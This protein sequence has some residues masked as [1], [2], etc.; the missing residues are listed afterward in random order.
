MTLISL[1]A[2]G[3]T[4]RVPLF[5]D[6]DLTLG[7]G[8]RLGLV[9]ANGRGKS[10][11]LRLIAGEGE[12][13]TG[14]I[15]R[16]R[17][18]RVGL[19]T[20]D[21]PTDLL[22]LTFRAAVMGDLDPDESWR[23]DIALD[24]F[25][26]PDA[27]RERPLAALSG[28]WQRTAMLARVWLG[29]PDVLLLDEP[30]NHLDLSRI[31][32][33]ERW[34]AALPRDMAVI[35]ASHDRAFLDAVCTRTLFLRP[36]ASEVFALPYTRARTALDE[37]D[38][39]RER[40]FQNDIARADQLRRQAAK[41]KNIGINSGSDLLVVKTKQ[42]TERA[43]K[44]EAAARPAHKEQ[45]SGAIRLAGAGS[46]AR[47]LLTLDDAEISA[48]DG[49]VLFRTGKLWISPG[50]RVVVLGPNGAGKSRLLAA[51]QAAIGG[52]PG[53][54]RAAPALRPGIS[55]QELTQLAAD[56][57][58]RE[59]ITRRSDIGDQ[60]ARALL[61]DAGMEIAAQDAPI[62]RLS[63][64]QKARLAMLVLRLVQPNFYV[65]DEPTNH[66][67]IEGQ[68]ALETELSAQEAAALVVSHDR[69][70]VTGIGTRFWLIDGKR[71]REVEGPEEYFRR[72][73]RAAG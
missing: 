63:G 72:A 24:D 73:M 69:R 48:P 17:G 71:L 10:T 2:L 5:R 38:A 39:A 60:R 19:T 1:R 25:E 15:T 31:G 54:I 21:V 62:A 30:T 7:K 26:V 32:W 23:G 59:A 29:E 33:L 40:R 28:G 56:R 3:Q 20:Q 44:L 41:L 65:L 12:P 9:A 16:A 57:T 35:L 34:I 53:A 55:D 13:T 49:R 51:V 37:A 8:D 4:Q 43:E 36:E 46:H 61:A 67:D 18:L 22:P 47:A 42:L 52:A 68:E 11:L 64:G 58:P 70:F 50:E 14:E 6:L 66:L 27:L 45:S